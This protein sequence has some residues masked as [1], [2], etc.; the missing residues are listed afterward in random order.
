MGT[1]D[2]GARR[3]IDRAQNPGYAPRSDVELYAKG[4]A[5]SRLRCREMGHSWR[6]WVARWDDE[7][8]SF[9]RALKCS[10]CQT[11]R[12]E[13]IGRT[14][15]KLGCYYKY[16]DGYQCDLGRI[17]GEGRDAL[18]LEIMTRELPSTREAHSDGAA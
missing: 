4:L 10:R 14:G 13:Y 3:L 5:T 9:Q 18:R 17:V 12:W 6:P 7:H 1:S 16:P 11:E 15:A 8:N 2:T